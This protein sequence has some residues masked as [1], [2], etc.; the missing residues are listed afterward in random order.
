MKKI[1]KF[2]V[3]PLIAASLSSCDFLSGLL[4]G[5][6]T[7]EVH[8]SSYEP[9]TGKF[10]LYETA[11]KRAE[12]TNTYFVFDGTKGD[13]SMKY[14]ENGA[15]KKEGVFQR[16]VTYEKYLGHIRDNL[17]FNVKCG[18]TIEHIATYTESFDPIDQ[19]RI[20]DE[21]DVNEDKY[22]LSELPYI[23]GTYVREG[24]TYKKE[25]KTTASKDYFIPTLENFTIELD[26]KF[27][28][29]DTH[30]FYFVNPRIN[31]NYAKAYFE[32]HSPS[33][34]KPLEGF[35]YGKTYQSSRNGSEIIFSYNRQSQLYKSGG[36][37]SEEGFVFG[38]YSVGQNDDLIEHWGSV[39]FS[40]NTL[41]SF[42]FE[43]LSRFWT[44]EE[45]D[46][47]TKTGS[48][49]TLPDPIYYEYVGGTYSKVND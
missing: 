23:M 19:F 44:D 8:Q 24:K 49:Y 47:W 41:K 37:S 21:Y 9:I 29:D 34:R 30:Y 40:N 7:N 16:V 33:L 11:D 48:T 4:G 46:Q 20:L 2:I 18:K 22:F 10:V 38:Y 25:A 13:F 6:D 27:A 42:T 43:H 31:D 39:D 45:M 17:H 28:L 26:G 15:L 5:G 3:L 1:F 35:A 12:V 32:Y 14:Y 36:K